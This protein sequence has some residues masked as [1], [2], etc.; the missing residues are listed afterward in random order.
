[1]YHRIKCHI[2]L[3]WKLRLLY[4]D[5]SSCLGWRMTRKLLKYTSEY[6]YEVASTVGYHEGSDLINIFK[7][8]NARLG[9]STTVKCGIPTWSVSWHSHLLCSPCFLTT[10]R[11]V[12]LLWHTFI[13]WHS[14][15][16]HHSLTHGSSRSWTEISK[17]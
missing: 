14:D 10:R 6:D 4:C 11:G 16:R 2:S 12:T 9:G 8:V 13:P 1:M 7:N 17:K 3:D 15:S 5:G